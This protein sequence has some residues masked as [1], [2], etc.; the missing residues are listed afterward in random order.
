[1]LAGRSCSACFERNSSEALVKDTSALR[2]SFS[3]S[4]S[5]RAGRFRVTGRC[6]D[7][8]PSKK[9]G[10]SSLSSDD[11]SLLWR[12]A[13][14]YSRRVNAPVFHVPL[15]KSSCVFSADYQFLIV[16]KVA[17][18][19]TNTVFSQVFGARQMSYDWEY[20]DHVCFLHCRALCALFAAVQPNSVI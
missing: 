17:S 20:K 10:S 3:Q 7:A 16:F 12:H 2:R 6:I 15:Q 18:S 4:S 1:M 13:H 5:Q 19:A 14:Q 11:N 8:A 9:S